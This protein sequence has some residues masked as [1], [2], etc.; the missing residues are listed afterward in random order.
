MNKFLLANLLALFTCSSLFSQYQFFRQNQLY[1][2]RYEQS[3]YDVDKDVHT[4]NRPLNIWQLDSAGALASDSSL[5]FPY[6]QWFWRK[7]FNEHLIEI[8]KEDYAITIDPI[9]NFQGG[10]GDANQARTYF[11]NTRGFNVEGRIGQQ[12]TF[13]T[14]YLENQ[15]F[16]PSYISDFVRYRRVVP[17]QGFARTFGDGGFDYGVPGG[18]ISYTPNK[19]FNFTVGQ[20]HNFFGEGYR[21]MMLSDAAFNY[22]FARI[23]TTFWR[24]KYVNLWS[25]MYDVRPEISGGNIFSKKFV[26]S[27]LLSINVTKRLNVSFF[28]SIVVGDTNQ[29]RGLDAS[30]FNPVIFYRPVEFAI[31]SGQ[32]NALLGTMASYKILDGL[33]AY[34]QFVLDEFNLESLRASNG[35]W[36]NKFGWQLGVKHYGSF[37]LSNLFT[38]IEWNAARPYTYS[39]R[40]VLTNYGHYGQPLA[41]PWGANFSEVLFQA[42]YQPNRY[43]FDLQINYGS[44]GLDSNGSNWGT[45]VYQSYN[46]RELDLGNEIGQGVNAQLL[47]VKLRLAYLVNP[48]SGLKVE[49][50]L[51]HRNLSAAVNATTPFN[52]S[53]NTWFF[54]GLR[55]EFLNRYYDF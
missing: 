5:A 20:G 1:S 43:E 17:G 6:K 21:S 26:S 27:H 46:T 15:A 45:D 36:V 19:F 18:E 48:A 42:I 37:G 35:S 40:Q 11:V 10:F 31:G 8:E 13:K 25:Q 30:F 49:T 41:H 33:Q 9:V 55:T 54:V 22:P 24:I 44:I 39:H 34:G 28:E 4:Q 51:Q 23:S 52:T 12:F 7:A 53:S 16:F 47:Y 3:A 38:R 29:V 2:L 50:G 14:Y 32:G